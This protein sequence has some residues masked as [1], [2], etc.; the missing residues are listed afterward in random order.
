MANTFSISSFSFTSSSR[1]SLFSFTTA[2][3]SM[4]SVEPEEDWSWIM[5]GHLAAVFRF[6]RETVAAVAHGNDIVLE[7]GAYALGIDHGV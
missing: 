3:G 6:N 2:M 7:L 5:P 4:N 1:R